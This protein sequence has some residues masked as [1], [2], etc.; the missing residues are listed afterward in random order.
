MIMKHS[1]RTAIKNQIKHGYL[2]VALQ[3]T[4][5]GASAEGFDNFSEHQKLNDQVVIATG[6]I[7]KLMRVSVDTNPSP[8]P[9]STK[10]EIYQLGTVCFSSTERLEGKAGLLLVDRIQSV[11]IAVLSTQINSIKV[12]VQ[13][14]TLLNCSMLQQQDMIN[15][16]NQ[17]ELQQKQNEALIKSIR[18]QQQQNRRKSSQ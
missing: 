15:I 11:S 13:P 18:Q 4:A 12:L 17:L 14:T 9:S 2:L 3:L 1:I 8:F 16:Q 5:I 6:N 10:P 7:S